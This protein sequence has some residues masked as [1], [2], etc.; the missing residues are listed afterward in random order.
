V[1]PPIGC[2]PIGLKWVYKVKRDEHGAVVR[3]KARLVAKGF[4]Q[5]E[6]I[7][8]EEVFA[9]VARMESVRLL[10]A[11]AAIKD[12]RVHHLDVKSAFLN[13]ELAEVIHV[14]QPPG[15]AVGG[16]EHKVLRLHKALYG[17]RQAPR[18]WN[19]KLDASLA[20][21]GFIK[22][23]TEHALYT[24]RSGHG[25]L[26]VGVYVDDLIVTGSDQ[27]AIVDF[28]IE[29]MKLFRMSDLGLLT[30]YLGLEVEQRKDAITL[31]QSSYA[32]KLLERSGMG[33]CKPCQTPM[34]EKLRLSKQSTAP[35]VDATRYRSIVGG[36]RYLVHTRPDIAF[37]VGFVSRFMEDPKEDHLAAVKHLLR[38]VAGTTS[39][40]LVYPR[41]SGKGLELTGFSDSDM[42][43]DIDGRKSTTGVFFTLGSCPVSWQSQKQKI[44]AL[45]T[46]EAEYIA[47]ATASCQGVWFGR[48]LQE[49]TGEELRAPLLK[50]DNKSAIALA[51]NPV[52]HDR[53][54]H[55]DTRFHF[56]RDCVDGG[57]IIL[58]HVETG[59]QLADILTKPLG[60]IRLM[61]LRTKIGM[62]E[63]K[64]ELT[65]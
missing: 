4:V 47:A 43:G 7:D 39:Y 61:E 18:A 10:L 48:M 12:W 46:C 55:I 65:D 26:I 44:V 63:L 35:K 16:Q 32:R 21:L 2:R 13:G 58:E 51:K 52:L 60:R 1:D 14:Q 45:S 57:Q 37:A 59:R 34:E 8:F 56:I 54:K 31:R 27:Q 17:L 20:T 30:Y 6:G 29:M 22:C 38:Y 41:R 36:L 40:G 53:S 28:K 50:V 23:V 15:F 3:H 49:L 42:A 25:L 9:P 62:E 5:R 24:R 64:D 33:D 19:I 11:L